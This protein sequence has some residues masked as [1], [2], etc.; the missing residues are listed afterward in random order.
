M[1]HEVLGKGEPADGIVDAQIREPAVQPIAVPGEL[2][3]YVS[4]NWKKVARHNDAYYVHNRLGSEVDSQVAQIERC[5]E[6]VR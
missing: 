2:L 5:G 3:Q 1:G 6:S 4:P